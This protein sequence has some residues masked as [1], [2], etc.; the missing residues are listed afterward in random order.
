MRKSR[1][2]RPRRPTLRAVS[3]SAVI[4]VVLFVVVELIGTV[5]VIWAIRDV[6]DRPDEEFAA[7]GEDRR[8]VQQRLV[9]SITL[10]LGIGGLAA[11]TWYVFKIRPR[12]VAA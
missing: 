4:L 1:R 6:R 8:Q 9:M 2:L 10:L 3:T 7:A 11:A 12:L 5:A